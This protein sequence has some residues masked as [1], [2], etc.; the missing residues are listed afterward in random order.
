[1]LSI[2]VTSKLQAN[3]YAR[4]IFITYFEIVF[5]KLYDRPRASKTQWFARVVT[6]I[7][8]HISYFSYYA[9]DIR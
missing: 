7:A 5:F 3:D 6:K 2:K 4:T 9:I 1:M 8:V